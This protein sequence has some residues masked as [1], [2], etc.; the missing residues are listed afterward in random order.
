[1]VISWSKRRKHPR[2]S[3]QRLNQKGQAT[4]FVATVIL[5]FVF[6]VTFVINTGLVVHA[7]INL[8]N[9]ADLAAYSGAAT[10]ARQLT[11]ISY[12]NYEMRRTYKKFLFRYYVL[13]NMAQ[14]TH[15]TSDNTGVR[16]WG[17]SPSNQIEEFGIPT[18]CI[19]MT[20]NDPQC[21]NIKT[22]SILSSNSISRLAGS[23]DT[24]M[25]AL[26]E[27]TKLI[28]KARKNICILNGSMNTRVLAMW[29]LNTDPNL[30]QF[31]ADA[32]RLTQSGDRDKMKEAD[33]MRAIAPYADGL[34]LIPKELLLR[35]RIKTLETVV[36]QAPETMNRERATEMERSG[37]SFRY[38][39]SLQAYLSAFN[40]L[41]E[42]LFTNPTDV[43]LKELLPVK[44]GGAD[45]LTLKDIS[46]TFDAYALDFGMKDN[47]PRSNPCDP[48][49]QN[50]VAS[51][52]AGDVKDCVPCLT[53]YSFVSGG[54]A[55]GFKPILG[56]EK[57]PD[58]L[59]Y[60][61]VRL[62]AKTRLMFS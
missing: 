12:L 23:N 19:R 37:E 3:R 8:Q 21:S 14:G 50:G 56:V 55:G 59:T 62:S 54:S 7:K 15:P 29:L 53:P 27:S 49:V 38:E 10:Q 16:K 45:L 57:D 20:E 33:I 2:L 43:V 47:D 9:A 18:V 60:Y 32:T 48:R 35:L 41:G 25:T 17:V 44:A 30:T 28:E 13:G 39:R 42:H 11:Y 26:Y 5:T 46:D 4:L 22:E 1:M 24:T 51:Q 61:A 36:N 40:S 58:V 6:F 52:T 31:N 34:G